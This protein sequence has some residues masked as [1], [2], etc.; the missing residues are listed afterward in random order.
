MGVDE[1]DMAFNDASNEKLDNAL[2]LT[3]TELNTEY[4]SVRYGLT[5]LNTEFNSSR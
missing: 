4:N 3:L 1:P 2:D 5:E